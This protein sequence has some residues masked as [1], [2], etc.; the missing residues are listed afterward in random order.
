M[1]DNIEVF[2]Q[3]SIKFDRELKIYFDPY[4]IKNSY[5]DADIIFITH[6]HYDH[7]SI[8]D[9]NQSQK[10]KQICERLYSISKNDS[11]VS[12]QLSNE[13]YKKL[14]ENSLYDFITKVLF[15]IILEKR[16]PIYV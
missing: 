16:Q 4:K 10:L 8:E 6:S 13:L 15:Y 3:S 12:I 7:L 1:L 2:T 14:E 9:I 5:N 11:D